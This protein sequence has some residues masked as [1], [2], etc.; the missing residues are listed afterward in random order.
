MQADEVRRRVEEIRSVQYDSEAAHS[1]EDRLYL[2]LLEDIAR[3]GPET[4]AEK[5]RIALETQ[6]MSFDRWCA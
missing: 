1:R 4:W 2:E 6:E 3:Q 5:A